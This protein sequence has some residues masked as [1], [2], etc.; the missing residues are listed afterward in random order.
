MSCCLAAPPKPLKYSLNSGNC[1]EF[2]SKNSLAACCVFSSFIIRGFPE[3][4]AKLSNV[5]YALSYKF[6]FSTKTFSACCLID[7]LIALTFNKGAYDCKSSKYLLPPA[8]SASD[9]ATLPIGDTSGNTP[10][11]LK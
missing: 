9:L 5:L 10:I 11:N 7:A 6:T 4:I 8:I 3:V 1:A 2:S